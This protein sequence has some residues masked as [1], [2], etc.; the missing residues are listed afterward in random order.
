[1][2]ASITLNCSCYSN[3]LEELIELFEN[4]G[5]KLTSEEGYLP[6]GDK[7]D[8]D[9][10]YDNISKEEMKNII[11]QKQERNELI[12]IYF[13][14]INSKE[15]FSVLAR[16]MSDICIHL[17]INR[18]TYDGVYTDFEWY[19]ENFIDFLEKCSALV[20][21]QFEESED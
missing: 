9:W 19:K 1:M 18:K 6:L 13:I 17:E 7:G 11:R 8:F 14:K 15:G 10:V 20:S 2:D 21:Y 12:G 16:E 4:I 5:W 3:Y